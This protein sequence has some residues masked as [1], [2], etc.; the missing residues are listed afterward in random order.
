MR[1]IAIFVLALAP[2]APAQS[3][4]DKLKQKV[5]Q[6]NKAG[7]SQQQKQGQPRQQPA[8]QQNSNPASANPPTSP[9]PAPA[10]DV[11]VL[12]AGAGF[13]EVG[14]MK[15]GMSVKDTMLA[16]RALNPD[17]TLQPNTFRLHGLGDQD[18][19]DTVAA[20]SASGQERITLAFTV[21]PGPEVLWG[22]SRQLRFAENERPMSGK[23]LAE[24]QKRYGAEGGVLGRLHIWVF[25]S[26][27]A[28]QSINPANF[29]TGNCNAVVTGIQADI[30]NGYQKRAYGR[31][32]TENDCGTMT[33]VTAD[34]DAVPQ[35]SQ[36]RL[37]DPP[38]QPV[39]FLTITMESL[40]LHRATVE[41]A[42]AVALGAQQKQD[43]KDALDLKNRPV[44][45]M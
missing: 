29:M 5:D 11:A 40:P 37:I 27:G 4:L 35:D 15:P 3:V 14:G 41:A 31:T 9:A 2:L 7:Q 16:L 44:P 8:P 43:A 6:L 21:P 42:R 18:L 45:K 32:G 17:L 38:E 24:L 26:R 20:Y 30:S 19:L 34:V 33:I 23:V 22:V 13:V 39:Q 36:G 28:R 1:T 25:D 12:A 10:G